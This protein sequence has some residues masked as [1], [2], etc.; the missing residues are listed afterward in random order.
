MRGYIYSNPQLA[1][2]GDGFYTFLGDKK[3]HE[4]WCVLR[5]DDDVLLAPVFFDVM[6]NLPNSVIDS[7]PIQVSDGINNITIGI[8]RCI[9]RLLDDLTTKPVMYFNPDKAK[10]AYNVLAR[11]LRRAIGEE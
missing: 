10:D 1:Y 4:Y 11:S 2:E 8:G 6:D 5:V 3:P 7:C 9:V